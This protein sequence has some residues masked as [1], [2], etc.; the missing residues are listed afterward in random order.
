MRTAG[1]ARVLRGWGEVDPVLRFAPQPAWGRRRSDGEFTGG[2]AVMTT[3]RDADE[4]RAPAPSV[5]SYGMGTFRAGP[6]RPGRA[7]GPRNLG[8]SVRPGR[9]GPALRARLFGGGALT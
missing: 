5:S 9:H 4:I 7:A 8:A 6:C 3:S 2:I 1:M